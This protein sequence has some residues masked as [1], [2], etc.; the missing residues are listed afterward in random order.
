MVFRIVSP[1]WIA[2]AVL[3]CSH[4]PVCGAVLFVSN[5]ITNTIDRSTK[6]VADRFLLLA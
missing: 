5:Y 1:L 2:L 3:F 6:A 4:L